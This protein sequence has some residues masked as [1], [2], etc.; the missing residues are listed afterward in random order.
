MTGPARFA[1]A[2]S[3]DRGA[4][5][6][7]ESM[8]FGGIVAP[9][10][11]LSHRLNDL[12][13]SREMFERGSV[14]PYAATIPLTPQHNQ[15]VWPIGRSVEAEDR[16]EG[17]WMRFELAPTPAGREAATLIDEGFIH[18]LSVEMMN[19]LRERAMEVDGEMVYVVESANIQGVGLVGVAAYPDAKITDMRSLSVV[20]LDRLSPPITPHRDD[21]SAWL[22]ERKAT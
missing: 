11:S 8:T 2:N 7:A 21:L 20:S 10:L 5:P 3:I 12:G 22:E 18:G 4:K 17:L 14:R 6:V 16:D 1:I 9:W 13:G 19:G 15:D